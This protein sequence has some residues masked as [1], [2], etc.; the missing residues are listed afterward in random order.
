MSSLEDKLR[1]QAYDKITELERYLLYRTFK[2][3]CY[4]FQEVPSSASAPFSDQTPPTNRLA[5][6]PRQKRPTTSSSLQRPRKTSRRLP[7][8]TSPRLPANPTLSSRQYR[9]GSDSLSSIE[10]S[11]QLDDK[12]RTLVDSY[13][14][15]ENLSRIAL[16]TAFAHR[17]HDLAIRAF[18][19][20]KKSDAF[21]R[22]A[23]YMLVKHR[24]K[25]TNIDPIVAQISTQLDYE[26]EY[27]RKEVHGMVCKGNLWR[28]IVDTLVDIDN[29]STGTNLSTSNPP[30]P[31]PGH[32]HI[33]AII[34][35]TITTTITT[36]SSGLPPTHIQLS[37]SLDNSD[38]LDSSGLS[39][40]P[41]AGFSDRWISPIDAK[42]LLGDRGTFFLLRFRRSS[43]WA[44]SALF[45]FSRR[46][47]WNASSSYPF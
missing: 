30:A 46:L 31:L 15:K 45:S 37:A 8:P 23:C 43:S 12:A 32:P 3:A 44:L 5:L 35:T 6:L 17:G 24:T 39:I 10:V 21:E 16:S 19:V 9:A 27:V 11:L 18:C 40:S 41:A 13:F 34:T 7:N 36:Y 42:V 28:D 4:L 20:K 38:A 2:E 14:K 33:R 25:N 1:S 22:I 26:P 29:S 47:R